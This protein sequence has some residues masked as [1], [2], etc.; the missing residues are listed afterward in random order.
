MKCDVAHNLETI[1]DQV[2]LKNLVYAKAGGEYIN[3]SDPAWK[4][5]LASADSV[6]Y[7]ALD[8][9]SAAEPEPVL[10]QQAIIQSLKDDRP[11]DAI[12]LY[13]LNYHLFKKEFEHFQEELSEQLLAA[14]SGDFRLVGKMGGT[15]IQWALATSAGI[16][17][18]IVS[19]PTHKGNLNDSL[20]QLE[21]HPEN[22]LECIMRRIV[23][24]MDELLKQV[25]ADRV[26]DYFFSAPGFFAA[27]GSLAEDQT[28][29]ANMKAGFCFDEEIPKYLNAKAGVALTGRTV[30]DGTGHA[31]GDK[32]VYGPFTL[33]DTLY[34]FWVGTGIASRVSPPGLVSFTGGDAFDQ[35]H[36]EL[37]HS[38]LWE[39]DARHFVVIGD[40]TKGH[41]PTPE[42]KKQRESLEERACGKALSQALIE[43]YA[44]LIDAPDD[45]HYMEAEEIKTMLS[46]LGKTKLDLDAVRA[47]A[48]Q[49]PVLMVRIY[50]ERAFEL[51]LG[52]GALLC[53]LV[54]REWEGGMRIELT[55]IK[56][57]VGGVIAQLNA[58]GLFKKVREGVIA[59][60][61]RRD[62]SSSVSSIVVSNMS[63]SSVDDDMRE[64]LGGLPDFGG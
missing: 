47:L 58:L 56:I 29:V 5:C 36:N 14:Y 25:G 62:I 45:K 40:E 12:R 13:T 55:S 8:L 11:Q 20:E 4:Q 15:E 24:P 16:V 1:I 49:Q 64:L 46:E 43:E 44:R 52:I 38:T 57:P 28:N 41:R 39:A 30:H 6:E 22:A 51:G 2:G 32:S 26:R 18:P 37:P 48:R 7:Q 19:C 50:Q 33:E 17:T 59:E 60:L 10:V 35:L 42:Q 54:D 3:F 53:Y 21:Q 63:M 27:D 31:F 9:S 61:T 23:A 34:G